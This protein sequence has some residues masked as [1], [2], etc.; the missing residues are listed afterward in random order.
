MYIK[1]TEIHLRIHLYT[2]TVYLLGLIL[3]RCKHVVNQTQNAILSICA[4]INIRIKNT[5]QI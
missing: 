4:S 5:I 2:L 1:C 3:Y